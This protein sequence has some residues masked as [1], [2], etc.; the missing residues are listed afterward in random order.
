[1]FQVSQT[2]EAD[3]RKIRLHLGLTNAAA[4]VKGSGHRRTTSP[5][6]LQAHACSQSKN[7]KWVVDKKIQNVI[8]LLGFMK[9][10]CSLSLS[11]SLSL[12]I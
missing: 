7:L 9:N 10:S 1:M 5:I 8:I 2:H 12:K 3:V 6:S 4:D 11:L